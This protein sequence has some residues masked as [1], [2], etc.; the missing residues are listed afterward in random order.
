[1]AAASLKLASPRPLAP[2]PSPL[3]RGRGAA[4]AQVQAQAQARRVPPPA[5]VAVQQPHAAPAHAA[6][7]VGSFDR[8]LEALIA[9]T[10]FS[11]GDA[12]AT[13]R[14]LLEEKDEARIAA[15]LVLLRAKG[16]TYE[17]VRARA[18]GS[19]AGGWEWEWEWEWVVM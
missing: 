17:E 8:V 5:R 13:L 14:L 10:D 18:A 16:E 19:V 15:F 7:R 11:E 3:L 4:P 6:P 12:E 9:G 1:M 2:A